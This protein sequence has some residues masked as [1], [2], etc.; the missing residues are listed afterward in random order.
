MGMRKNYRI[1]LQLW[2]KDFRF[3]RIHN[4]RPAVAALAGGDLVALP[5]SAVKG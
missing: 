2:Q 1:F 4:V 5:V 3:Q